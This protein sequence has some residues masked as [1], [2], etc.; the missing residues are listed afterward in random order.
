MLPQPQGNKQQQ[1]RQRPLAY[2]W[3]LTTLSNWNMRPKASSGRMLCLHTAG[4]FT[5][6]GSLQ[7]ATRRAMHKRR[8]APL[9][10]HQLPLAP[11]LHEHG[12]LP[13]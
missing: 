9:G 5:Q 12:C 2:H 10:E 1:E 4:K 13:S 8:N 6:H 3:L 11:E 7:S